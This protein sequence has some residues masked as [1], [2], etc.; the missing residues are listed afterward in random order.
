MKRLRSEQEGA[1]VLQ[2]EDLSAKSEEIGKL[3]KKLEY[4]K[5]E[6]KDLIKA[7]NENA[8]KEVE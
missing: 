6:K 3:N 8:K 7:I 1:A 5:N 4:L 2:T